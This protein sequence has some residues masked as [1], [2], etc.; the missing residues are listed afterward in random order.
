MPTSEILIISLAIYF[1]LIS[2]LATLKPVYITARKLYLFRCL[3]PSWKFYEDIGHVPV[4]YYRLGSTLEMNES[5][6]WTLAINKLDRSWRNLFLNPEGNLVHAYN[7]LLQQL[8]ND[9]ED[10]AELNKDDLINTA[11]YNLTKNLV[12]TKIKSSDSNDMFFQFK[13]TSMMQGSVCDLQDIL[14]SAVHRV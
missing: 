14:I 8:E 11:S 10:I 6:P 12:I 7:S 3:F 5:G 2:R 1:I 9:K 4:L 13:L